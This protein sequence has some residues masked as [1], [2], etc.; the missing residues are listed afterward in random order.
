MFTANAAR[1]LFL[2]FYITVNK[3]GS[4]ELGTKLTLYGQN[5]T[6]RNLMWNIN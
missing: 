5:H 4:K 6:S 3:V 2:Q 1:T